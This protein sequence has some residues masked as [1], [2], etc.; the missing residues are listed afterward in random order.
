M[1][2]NPLHSAAQALSKNKPETSGHQMIA[3]ISKQSSKYRQ[4]V[5]QSVQGTFT[6][7]LR[8]VGANKKSKMYYRF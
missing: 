8:K 7:I 1:T 5:H 2:F 3:N 6:V 4:S